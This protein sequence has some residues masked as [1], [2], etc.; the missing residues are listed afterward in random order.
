MRTISRGRTARGLRALAVASGLI[1]LTALAVPGAARADSAEPFSAAQLT[2]AAEAVDAADVGG[3]AWAVDEATGSVHVLVDET[4]GKAE[5]AAIEESAGALSGALD[6]ERTPGTFEQYL[7]GGDAIY[8]DLGW[9]C[10]LGFNVRSGSTFYFLT[11]GHCTEDPYGPTPP[12][13]L[14]SDGVSQIGYTVSSYFPGDDF[15]LVQYDPQPASVPS[16]VL[17]GGTITAFA[18][19][20]VGQAVCRSG[21]TTGVWCGSV[22]GLGYTVDYGGGDVVYDMI[23]TN[24]CA[25]PGDS[26]G[27]LWYGSVGYGLTSGGSGNCSSG[28]TTFYQR[29][30]EAAAVSG[31]TLP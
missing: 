6:I 24:V 29:V 4:V 5:I 20:A 28:G 27:P 10:S 16:T 13:P 14:W 31:V 30:T 18:D 22:T 15:G 12:Y 8:A 19:P 9:R 25:E 3:T 2:T 11:A 26:G 17:G 7:Q 23:M 1:A 21:S